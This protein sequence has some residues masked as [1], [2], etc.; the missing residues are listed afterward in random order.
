MN[1]II[2]GGTFDPIHNGHLR[3]AKAI[4]INFDGELI[5]VPSKSPRWKTPLTDANHR[6]NMLKIAISDYQIKGTIENYELES[7]ADINYSIDTVKY[8][9]NK[10]PNDKL[11]FVIG[12]DQV[13]KFHLWKD[14]DVISKLTQIIFVNRPGFELDLENINKFNMINSNIYDSG[15]ISSSEIRELQSIDTT[16]G[17]LKYIET[18][19]LYYIKKME[20]Y[21][22]PKRLIHSISVENLAMEINKANNYPLDKY[23]VYVAALLHDIGKLLKTDIEDEETVKQYIEKES[24]EDIK[25]LPKFA[26]HQFIGAK[27][28]KEDFK[29][30]DEEI[31]EAIRYHATGK[32]DMS[33]LSMLV[34]ASDKIDPLR[35]FDSTWLINSCKK[36]IYQGFIDT[37]IDNKKYLINHKKDIYN[38]FTKQCFDMYIEGNKNEKR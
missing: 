4:Q 21:I 11:L 23:K 16:D 17:V 28:A 14:G 27:I 10:Y 32:K 30:N 6:L 5:F 26:Y 13:N 3:I 18:N 9:K 22:D 37:L 31:L 15:D 25:L 8:L 19:H 1:K 29:I 12:A 7:E 20:K 2:F 38:I 33:L 35:D 36:D 34:Y 24:H